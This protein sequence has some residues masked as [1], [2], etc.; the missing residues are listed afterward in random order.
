GKIIEIEMKNNLTSVFKN[1]FKEN[2]MKYSFFESE[3][4]I[5]N[6]MFGN[7]KNEKFSNINVSWLSSAGA[8]FST[9]QEVL[10]SSVKKVNEFIQNNK[11]WVS[12][13]SG[14][15]TLN[16]KETA[17]LNGIFRI[18]SPFGIIYYTPG[19]IPGFSSG[20]IYS[21]CLETAIAYSANRSALPNFHGFI[22]R[23]IFKNL[24]H[25][26]AYNA[27]I[28]KKR[29]NYNYCENVTPSDNINFANME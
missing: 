27:L 4:S 21:P 5:E 6:L 20:F 8:I 15:I 2:N 12:T 14:E 19:L 16:I 11:K 7:E 24:Y 10:I 22:I 1:Y 28:S 26:K 3:K 17:Y 9:P 25:D 29:K 18:N 23:K 13:K